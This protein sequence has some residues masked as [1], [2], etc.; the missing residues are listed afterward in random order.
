MP[1]VYAHAVELATT[2]LT[3]AG[4]G[5]YLVALV[6]AYVYLARRSRQLREL[7]HADT[8]FTPPL[9]ILK[10]LKGLDPGMMEAFRSHCR[11]SYAGQ[12][13]IL[14]GVSSQDDPA[15]AAVLRLQ[16]EFP[17]T[18][19]RL[20]ETPERLGTNGKVS[21]L[22]QLIPHA[23]HPYLLINDS[24]ITV[25]PRYLE[26]V[27][28]SF[29][30]PG[31]QP[32][33]LVTALY[34]GRAHGTLPSQLESLGISTDFLPSVLLTV[35]MER[36]MRFGLGSTL[37][38]TREAVE[39]AGGLAA[40]ADHLADDYELGVRVHKAGF[41]VV[42]APDV[43]ET[44]VPAYNWRGFLDHQL[45]W[46]RTVRD[47]RPLG[48][49]G[50]HFTYGLAWAMLNLMASGFSLLSIWLFALAFFLRLALA[51]TVGAR[52]LSDRQ[53]L[54]SLWL[55]PFRDAVAF[56]LWIAGFAGNTIVWRGQRFTVKKG[57]L[58]AQG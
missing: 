29:A 3:V 16:N 53:A 25:S 30:E 55:L 18:P 9:S 46:Y 26:R 4:M 57:K 58:I 23:A 10:S 47:A 11:Q 36:G 19:I 27:M 54:P 43:V 56:G 32:V 22:V 42:L 33:G 35:L 6:A 38:V 51:M 15:V 44:S 24:D 52:I 21:T 8:P 39:A 20:I 49:S 28:A 12:Y 45:R 13:E 7:A 48:Y 2:V 14:F 50:M 5:Y 41:R 40:L 37:A 1:H 31:K 34:R 17:G